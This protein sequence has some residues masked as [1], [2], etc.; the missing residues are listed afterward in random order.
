MYITTHRLGR[1]EVHGGLPALPPRSSILV[2]HTAALENLR[3]TAGR[4]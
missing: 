3:V 1:L 4:C 2:S